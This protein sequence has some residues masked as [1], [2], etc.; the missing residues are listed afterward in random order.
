MKP[1]HILIIAGV[2]LAVG[3]FLWVKRQINLLMAMT[4]KV[5]DLRIRPAGNKMVKLDFNLQ[6]TNPSNVGIT[7]KDYDL[8][9]FGNGNF[10]SKIVAKGTSIV[11][12]K[13]GQTLV[14]LSL[15][16][17]PKEVGNTLLSLAIDTLLQTQLVI[18]VKGSLSAGV[19]TSGIIVS[20]SVPVDYSNNLL[21]QNTDA[22]TN[23]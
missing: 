7:I 16:F 11:I 19:G 14:P 3:G 15:T 12:P 21:S 20:T 4:Y 8:D 22:Q 5:K 17:L 18:R 13:N 23:S 2:G 6:L 1:I 10:I 9:V